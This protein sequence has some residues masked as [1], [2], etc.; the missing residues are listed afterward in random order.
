MSDMSDP[1]QRIGDSDREAA[2]AALRV[3]L[4]MGRLTSTEYEDRSIQAGQAR[5]RADLQPLFADLPQPHPGTA[6]DL[7]VEGERSATPSEP[8]LSA[9]QP[10]PASGSAM[11]Q[12]LV[13]LIRTLIPFAALILFIRTGV[14]LWFLLIPIVAMTLFNSTEEGDWRRRSRGRRYR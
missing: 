14:W 1:A 5:T 4:G 13:P 2:V 9:S 8:E 7:T 12:P 3:H 11:P 10:T 6:S